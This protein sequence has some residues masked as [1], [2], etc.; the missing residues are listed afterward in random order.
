[1]NA[2]EVDAL[3]ERVLNERI[4]MLHAK[5]EVALRQRDGFAENLH[6]VTKIPYQERREILEDCNAEIE[7]AGAPK[8]V[9]TND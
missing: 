6:A 1:M 5:L 4:R 9:G 8:T 2:Q 3:K 7:R